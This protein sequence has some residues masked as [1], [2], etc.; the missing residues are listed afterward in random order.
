[1]LRATATVVIPARAMTAN[2]ESTPASTQKETARR[3]VSA[4]FGSAA[5]GSSDNLLRKGVLAG[6]GPAD[7]E[8]LDLTRTFV[9]GRNA[10]IL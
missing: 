3:A 7:D 9:E 8:L 2:S 6:Q 10:R 5:S 4:G 1:M